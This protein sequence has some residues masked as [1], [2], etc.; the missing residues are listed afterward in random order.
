M[1]IRKYGSG[2]GGNIGRVKFSTDVNGNGGPDVEGRVALLEARLEISLSNTPKPGQTLGEFRVFSVVFILLLTSWRKWYGGLF[3]RVMWRREMGWC[4]LCWLW[5]GNAVLDGA[6]GR[7]PDS[8]PGARWL[9]RREG[10][11]NVL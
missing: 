7:I 1:K 6:N 9:A 2:G 5:Y 11:L 8:F 4:V 10:G 3:R